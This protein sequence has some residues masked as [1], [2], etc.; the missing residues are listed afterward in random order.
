[1]KEYSDKIIPIFLEE[2]AKAYYNELGSLTGQAAFLLC[3]S[4]EKK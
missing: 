2:L 1:M 4:D 3:V